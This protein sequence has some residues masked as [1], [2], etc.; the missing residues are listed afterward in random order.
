MTRWLREQAH[1]EGGGSSN[2]GYEAPYLNTSKHDIHVFHLEEKYLVSD[3]EDQ[4]YSAHKS[5]PLVHLIFSREPRL[6]QQFKSAPI[7]L[8]AAKY[9]RSIFFLRMLLKMGDR[10]EARFPASEERL[11][12]RVESASSLEG[13]IHDFNACMKRA[14]EQPLVDMYRSDYYY[15]AVRNTLK[16]IDAQGF[17]MPK[18]DVKRVNAWFDFSK[19]H[20]RTGEWLKT[21][22]K[23]YDQIEKYILHK[24]RAGGVVPA[25]EIVKEP[26][27]PLCFQSY[28]YMRLGDVS[29][30]PVVYKRDSEYAPPLEIE[31]TDKQRVKLLKRKRVAQA[32]ASKRQKQ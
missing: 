12:L 29:E 14:Y 5:K 16:G 30:H 32:A 20:S 22:T 24:E 26:P 21:V 13:S 3:M 15:S 6:A 11:S 10:T 2:W 18:I 23:E 1:R 8:V 4:W 31:C 17:A 25:D 19:T 28:Y 7:P 9:K 27:N